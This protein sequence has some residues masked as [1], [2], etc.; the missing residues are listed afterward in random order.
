MKIWIDGYEANVKQRLGSSQW[1]YELIN[2]LEKLDRKNSYTILLPSDPLGDLPKP[3][4][5]WQYKIL[6]P[7]KL[8]TKIAL[9]KE[10]FLSKDK[11]DVFFSPTHYIPRFAPS[12]VKKIATI[13]DMSFLHFPEMFEKKDLW[14]L[15]NGTKFTAENADQIVT[16]SNSS[17]KDILQ[18]YHLAKEKVTVIYPGF[19]QT[20]FKM[21]KKNG[22]FSSENEKVKIEEAKKK[23]QIKNNYIIYIGTIQPRKNLVRLTEAFARIEGNLQLVIAGKTTGEGQQGWK[24]E[25]ILATPKRLQVEDRVKFPGFVETY[26]LVHLLSGAEAFI[27]PSLYEGFGIPVAEAMA[28]GTPVIVS[29]VSSLPEVVGNA[30]ILINPYSIDQIE[31]A[32]RVMVTDHKLRQ[33]YSK[34]G[35][36]QAQKFSWEKAAKELLKVLLV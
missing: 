35:L 27:L 4:T 29:N 1:A 26:D 2:H 25:E 17:K 9:P 36:I 18:D 23:Y 20:K 15:T 13:F 8:W 33:K 31:Q 22:S 19:D 6:K 7:K 5:N 34:L 14:Q 30:G 24:F 11:P 3:R 21:K 28:T 16:I 32:I 12:S 10:L